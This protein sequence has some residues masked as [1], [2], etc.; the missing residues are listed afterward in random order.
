MNFHTANILS[1]HF[2][3]KFFLFSDPELNVFTYDVFREN[4]ND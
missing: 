1:F 3:A 4:L 2:V